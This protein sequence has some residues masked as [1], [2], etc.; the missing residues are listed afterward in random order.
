MPKLQS[1]SNIKIKTGTRAK[2]D[3]YPT[4]RKCVSDLLKRVDFKGNIWEP[5][6]GKGDISEVLLDHN[7]T[8]LST[9][10]VDHGY[11]KLVSKIDFL[12]LH[13]NQVLTLII[14]LH[15]LMIPHQNQ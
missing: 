11:D 7:H 15:P 3:L 9:D 2:Y 14:W 5:A 1:K 4:P 12:N 13:L 8:V 6:C 10:I